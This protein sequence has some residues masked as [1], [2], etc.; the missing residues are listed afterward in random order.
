MQY[1]ELGRT[2]QRL[3][4]VGFGGILVV[5][6]EQAE[7]D[8]LVAAAVARGV[9]YFDVAPAYGDGEAEEKL[10]PALQPHR[11]GAFLACKTR[12]RDAAGARA[13]LERSLRRLR[14]DHF[15]LYQLHGL[16]EMADVE[17]VLGPGGALEVLRR[18]REE[19]K[20]R[21]LGFS[22]HSPAAALRLL[23][24]F[25]FDSVLFPLNFAAYQA[26]FGPQVVEAARRAGA[27]LLALKA[28][29]LTGLPEGTTLEQRPWRK[30]WYEPIAEPGTAELALRFTL[31]LPVTAAITPGYWEFFERALRVAEDPRALSAEEAERLRELAARTVPLFPPA[32]GKAVPR[33]PS[34]ILA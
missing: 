5:G 7:T 9:N 10:G 16:S 34:R 30:A 26:G 25:P 28:M 32:P 15:D 12:E 23:G 2:G 19:G 14:T 13:D 22:A 24:A 31:S 21:F 27:G 20:A 4:L 3:S 29:A 33:P 18:A 17:R 1:R 11:A 8:R 6:E